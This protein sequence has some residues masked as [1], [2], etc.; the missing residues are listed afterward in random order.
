M[1]TAV[2]TVE[3]LLKDPPH[4]GHSRFDLS[5]KDKFCVPTDHDNTVTS[6]REQHWYNSN[7]TSK[8]TGPKLSIM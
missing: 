2:I 5:I 6:E 7:I 3:Q 8:L 1:I 4:R